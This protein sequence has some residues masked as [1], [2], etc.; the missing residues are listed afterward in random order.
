MKKLS[1]LHINLLDSYWPTIA[2]LLHAG[3]L[4][5]EDEITIEQIRLLIVHGKAYIIVALDDEDKIVGACAMELVLYPNYRAA[6]IIAIGGNGLFVD[7]NDFTQLA[8][9]LKQ[10][11]CSKV[12]GLCPPSV[13]RLWKSKL[14]FTTPYTLVRKDL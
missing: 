9:L 10:A 1:Y 2:P 5:A 12:Q 4:Y 14:G 8:I 7:E 13:T 3:L 11:G 6:N